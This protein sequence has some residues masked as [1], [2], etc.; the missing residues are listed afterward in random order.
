[1]KVMNWYSKLHGTE[2][3]L[4]IGTKAAIIKP[5]RTISPTYK[6]IHLGQHQ[7]QFTRPE[8]I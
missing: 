2:T 1:M 5:L 4:A 8:H 3:V 6:S 7:I